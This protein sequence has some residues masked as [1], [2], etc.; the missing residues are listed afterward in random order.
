MADTEDS[1]T[2]DTGGF[3]AAVNV[4][5]PQFG[6][7]PYRPAARTR[8]EAMRYFERLLEEAVGQRMSG[9]H[10][11]IESNSLREESDIQLGDHWKSMEVRCGSSNLLGT[12]RVTKATTVLD[13]HNKVLS[14]LPVTIPAY[15]LDVSLRGQSPHSSKT[16]GEL[17]N[18][19]LLTWPGRR[20]L[21][22]SDPLE[23]CFDCTKI[24]NAIY[25]KMLRSEVSMLLAEQGSS[26][27]SLCMVGR[28]MK[29]IVLAFCLRPEV[30]LGDVGRH[31]YGTCLN[32]KAIEEFEK[33]NPCSFLIDRAN[34]QKLMSCQS[35]QLLS[36]PFQGSNAF[37]RFVR[38][39]VLFG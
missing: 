31:N 37:M 36:F 16:L 19:S 22:L 9:M 21:T 12:V 2:G 34:L 32:E 7:E 26:F 15:C 13:L 23:I 25:R 29:R 1:K 30:I 14:L 35:A 10:L 33:F 3:E 6:P 20:T 27:D 39:K 24:H 11:E 18:S 17:A 8:D 38:H 5:P 28:Q 4:A